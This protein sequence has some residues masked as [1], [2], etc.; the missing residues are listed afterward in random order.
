MPKSKRLTASIPGCSVPAEYVFSDAALFTQKWWSNVVKTDAFWTDLGR[1]LSQ[2]VIKKRIVIG[3]NTGT[4]GH[5]HSQSQSPSQSQQKR[6]LS[7]SATAS[8]PDVSGEGPK[9]ELAREVEELREM[10]AEAGD[11]VIGERKRLRKP[12]TNGRG[13]CFSCGKLCS[14]YELDFDDS[15]SPI[16]TACMDDSHAKTDNNTTVEVEMLNVQRE[17][18]HKSVGSSQPT[19]Q[20]ATHVTKVVNEAELP[21]GIPGGRTSV[22]SRSSHKRVREDSQPTRPAT[23][24]IKV[25]DDDVEQPGEMRRKGRM[26]TASKSRQKRPHEDSGQ[27]VTIQGCE[28]LVYMDEVGKAQLVKLEEQS[29]K[30]VKALGER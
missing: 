6:D 4:E 21:G 26:S 14:W 12:N 19:R 23:N 10:A 28:F 30:R 11:T 3:I 27:M 7:T 9:D 2:T 24:V 18:A 25:T 5:G 16:C 17:V 20:P 8:S 22:N 1:H 29:S 13:E 15:S